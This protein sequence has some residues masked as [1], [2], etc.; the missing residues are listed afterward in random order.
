MQLFQEQGKVN[1]DD[2]GA[3]VG[4]EALFAV[5]RQ[6]TVIETGKEL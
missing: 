6:E 5:Y 4:T 3:V 1:K 2:R